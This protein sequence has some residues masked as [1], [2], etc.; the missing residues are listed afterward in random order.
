MI[1]LYAAI[2]AGLFYLLRNDTAEFGIKG[3]AHWI[4]ACLIAFFGLMVLSLPELSLARYGAAFGAYVFLLTY[5]H[6]PILSPPWQ[7]C[8]TTPDHIEKALM[9]WHYKQPGD[10]M[11][12]LMWGQYAFARYVLP[13][14]VIGIAI[15][16]PLFWAVGLACVLG[17]WPFAYWV[18]KGENTKFVGAAIAGAAVFGGLAL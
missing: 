2:G 15:D 12:Y 5:A 4:L 7:P 10:K 6:G 13:C 8:S 11:G 9:T 18:A 17:Y 1:S 3:R 16:N 14:G